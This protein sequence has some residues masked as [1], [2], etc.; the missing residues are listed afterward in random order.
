MDM[1]FAVKPGMRLPLEPKSMSS[2]EL[3]QTTVQVS[4]KPGIVRSCIWM[5]VRIKTGL[6]TI[7]LSNLP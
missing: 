3:E 7:A 1:I 4:V 2:S 5:H 6:L